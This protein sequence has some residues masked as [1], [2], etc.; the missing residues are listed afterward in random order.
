MWL[1]C[2]NTLSGHE[3]SIPVDLV[4]SLTDWTPLEG[5]EPSATFA[6]ATYDTASPAPV[7]PPVASSTPP[8]DQSGT[9]ENQGD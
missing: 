4:E 6:D 2:R 3:A 5:A 7:D 1:R 9:P 8:A